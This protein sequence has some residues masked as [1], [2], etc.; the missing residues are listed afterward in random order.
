MKNQKSARIFLKSHTAWI[1]LFSFVINVTVTEPV[2]GEIIS[3]I[4][5]N[6]NIGGE[7][8]I[9]KNPRVGDFAVYQYYQ[10]ITSG[11]FTTINEG[12]KKVEIVSI[13]TGIIVVKESSYPGKNISDYKK[14]IRGKAPMSVVLYHLDSKGIIKKATLQ[15]KSFG[16]NQDFN[17][18]GPGKPGYMKYKKTGKTVKLKTGAGTFR[19]RAIWYTTQNILNTEAREKDFKIDL[20]IKTST[21]CISYINHEIKFLSAMNQVNWSGKSRID[22]KTVDNLLETLSFTDFFKNPSGIILNPKS[23][24]MFS[25]IK[26]QLKPSKIE[27]LAKK[28]V[29]SPK[30][31][32]EFEKLSGSRIDVL[33]EYGSKE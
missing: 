30:M 33:L 22:A 3:D 31:Q 16:V 26:S 14:F 25:Y 21:S 17:T 10:K 32:S 9:H 20:D 7:Y 13:N 18:V 27:E 11:K 28:D 19:V 15:M 5:K 23:F 1:L 4:T 6:T 2:N 29:F 8:L 24:N 12:I